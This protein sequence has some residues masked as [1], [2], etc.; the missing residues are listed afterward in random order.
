MECGPALPDSLVLE[1][2]LR[3][4]HDA[5]LRAGLTCRQWLAVSRDEF[6]W[7]EL[8][9]SYYR[10]PRSVPRHPA[11]VSWYREFRRLFDCIPCVEVQTLREHTDQ[12]LHLAFSHRGHRFSSCS[13]DCTVKLWDTERSDGNIS[14]VHSSSMRQFNWG[15]TQF[16]QF[17][18]DDTL[19]LVSG[20]YL[21]PHH[22]S[23]G[24]IAVISLENYTLLSRVRNKP[25]D[26]FGCWLNETHLISGNLHWIGNMTSCSVL[27]LN[28]AFQDVESEN[29][30]VVKR[31]FKIQN[32]NASTI[33]TVMVAH[34]RRHDNPD[35]LLDYEAQSQARRL[36]GQ[37]QEQH[38]PL[39]FDLGTS[40]SEEEEEEEEGG[41]EARLPTCRLPQPTI[42]GLEHILQS[43]KNVGH[44]E[45]AIETHVAKMMGR[46]HTKAP[47]SSLIEPSVPG[48]GEDKTYLLF[49]TGSL[50]YSPH[51]IGIK[52]IKPDQMTTCGPVLGEERSSDEFF[53]SLDHVIDIHGHIIGMGLSPDHRYL[54][55]NSRAW[56]AGCVISDPMSPPPIA[57]EI[58][59]H[60][61]DLKSLREERRSLRAHRAFTPNDECFFI[62]LD[63][64]R[65]FVASGAEDKHGYIWDRHYNICLARLA[66]DDVVN[67]VAFS[68]AD[69]ELLLSASDDST[70]KVWRSPRMVRLAQAPARPPRPRGLLSSWLSRSKNSTSSSS[71]NGKP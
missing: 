42:S 54:Y 28:K 70:I 66:H 21:G 19:L 29:V 6:L 32:V 3:L 61:I 30:N 56:P 60:V 41:Q 11:A 67:S 43:R 63:V 65:D 1:I 33:R 46:A 45:L 39:L 36:K 22:S 15:Y 26:V 48:E 24:E 13:K 18:A 51:Q 9:Y 14:L 12:V 34:C 37:Q 47:D 58:D 5:V 40:G 68:P 57:E 8:F 10:I 4:P 38:Q 55:V 25:Y 50:T 35:L 16:S 62:F 52:R 31:L 27:W 49:T 69:Q 7:R 23:S 59:L 64:S 44:M 17:N 20:V 53:D 2:F 71:V